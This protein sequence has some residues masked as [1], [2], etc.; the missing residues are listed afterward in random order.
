MRWGLRRSEHGAP[1]VVRVPDGTL[2]RGELPPGAAAV[3]VRAPAEPTRVTLAD[4]GYEA[5]LPGDVA[6]ELV[7]V[8]GRD[9]QGVIVPWPVEGETKREV[10]ADADATCPACGSRD[11]DVVSRPGERTTVCHVCGWGDGGW[12]Q[13]GR[14]RPRVVVELGDE[15]PSPLGDNPTTEDAVAAAAFPV[16]GLVG[17]SSEGFSHGWTDDGRTTSVGFSYE[18]PC[19]ELRHTIEPHRGD[20]IDFARSVL[21]NAISADMRHGLQDEELTPA[22]RA[23]AH[24]VRTRAIRARL[25]TLVVDAVELEVDG[26]PTMFACARSDGIEAAAAVIDDVRVTIVSRKRPIAELALERLRAAG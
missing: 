10:L 5:L 16:F 13:T 15:V 25:D 12:T 24:S 11:W 20:P 22:A 26:R 23:L 4:G 6:G 19:V 7:F 18:G 3:E 9:E 8:L 2:L 1:W 14:R 17:E 21:R